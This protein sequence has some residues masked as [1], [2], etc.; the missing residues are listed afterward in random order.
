MTL[1]RD[2]KYLGK[3]FHMTAIPLK[4]DAPAIE[5]GAP[6]TAWTNIYR[7]GAAAALLIVLAGLTDIFIMFIPVAGT[8]TAPGVR[9]VVDWFTLLQSRPFVT[10]RDMGLLNMVTI[11]CSVVVYFALF[12]LHRRSHPQAA[13]LALILAGLGAAIY[14]ANNTALPMLTL[15]RHYAAA[16]S[17]AQKALWAAAGQ[18]WLARED[19]T[20]GAFPAFFFGEIAGLLM[21]VVILGGHIF[22][23][24]EGW[25][26]LLGTA[27]LLFF[28]ICAAF[29][30]SL[31]DRVMLIFGAGGGLLNLVWYILIARRLLSKT[32]TIT[33]EK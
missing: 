23:R 17:E 3:D 7:A 28:N 18:A 29:I 5:A 19:L 15:S 10:L 14:V 16:A 11:S 25:I 26:Y 30:P 22:H 31:Y 33:E 20:A 27:C 2:T 9:S 4:L 13:A 32:L 21:A 12:G 24:W 1:K 6:P 8:G